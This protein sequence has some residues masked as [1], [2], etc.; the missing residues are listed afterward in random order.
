M[1]A[2]STVD[3]GDIGQAVLPFLVS[4]VMMVG[5]GWWSARQLRRMQDR[6]RR[7]RGL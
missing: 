2:D 6:S 5:V 1:T 3:L 4:A 7:H